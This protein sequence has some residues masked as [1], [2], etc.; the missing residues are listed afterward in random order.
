MA[1]SSGFEKGP[2]FVVTTGTPAG[3]GPHKGPA[4]VWSWI[5]SQPWAASHS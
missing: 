3:A 4:R 1:A 5:T 2:W